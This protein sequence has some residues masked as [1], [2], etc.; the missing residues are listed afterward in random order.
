MKKNIL[1]IKGIKELNKL[2]Q[3]VIK[4]ALRPPPPPGVN[5]C[6]WVK[7]GPTTHCVKGICVPK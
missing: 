7:C 5:P 2:E 3:K 6:I 4:G 1:N